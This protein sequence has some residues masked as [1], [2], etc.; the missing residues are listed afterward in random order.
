MTKKNNN[1]FS[2]F[3]LLGCLII[4]SNGCKK[5]TSAEPE[6]VAKDADGNVYNTVSIGNQVWMVENLKTTKYNDGTSIPLV[7]GQIEWVNKT[8]AAYCWCLND[9]LANKDTY[10][11]LY[12]WYAVNSGKLAPAG[13]HV[14]TDADW[15]ILINYLGG[16]TTGGGKLK[17]AGTAH[18]NAPNTGATNATGFSALPGGYRSSAN[19][20]FVN[21]GVWGCWWSST[22]SISGFGRFI[23]RNT[24]AAIDFQSDGGNLGFNVRCVK[25]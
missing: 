15:T 12:N 1:W 23:L 11:A 14:A 4:L 24:N 6:I 19:G 20:S 9:S 18:W 5:N 25:N 16:V 3:L 10:G 21:M 13:W 7:T 17:E 2:S 22:G 8:S